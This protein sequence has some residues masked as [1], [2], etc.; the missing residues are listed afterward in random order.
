[1]PG[2]SQ[3]FQGLRK[4]T[5]RGALG[6]AALLALGWLSACADSGQGRLDRQVQQLRDEVYALKRQNEELRRR[7]EAVE[8]ANG[9][10]TPPAAAPAP[11]AKPAATPAPAAAGAMAANAPFASEPI[12]VTAEPADDARASFEEGLAFYRNGNHSRAIEKLSQFVAHHPQDARAAEAQVLV[13]ESYYASANFAQA[14][15]EYRKL[16]DK[17]PRSDKLPNALYGLGVSYYE[18]DYRS[19]AL[20]YLD[21]LVAEYPR[22]PQAEQAKP[23]ILKL[24]GHQR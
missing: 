2:V 12:R 21:R 11:A 15:V 20:S 7:I 14:V 24:R 3:P 17:Y 18:L 6:A 19:N 10:L 13:G 5:R 1:M 16:V 23:L 8:P 22:S 4:T 9:N